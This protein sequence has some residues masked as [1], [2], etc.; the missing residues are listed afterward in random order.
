MIN[1]FLIWLILFIFSAVAIY[2]IFFHPKKKF[3]DLTYMKNKN[4]LELEYNR[5]NEHTYHLEIIGFFR[6]RRRSLPR[7]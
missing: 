1:P 6:T 2:F 5:L 3:K 7:E 4:L